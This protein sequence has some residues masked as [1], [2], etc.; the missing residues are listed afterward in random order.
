MKKINAIINEKVY[1]V[2]I[3]HEEDDMQE[4]LQHVKELPEDE[5]ML[6]IFA[7]DE[8]AI[9]WMKDTEIPLKMLFIDKDW[10]VLRVVEAEPMNEDLIRQKGAR[11]V[12]E[13]NINSEVEVGDYVDLDEIEIEDALSGEDKKILMLV[14]D[15]H[16]NSQMDLEGGERIFSRPNT[17]TLIK[18]ARRAHRTKSDRDY[19]AL[20]RKIFAYLKTQDNNVQETV[21]IPE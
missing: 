9:M 18:M 12:L 20:G 11:Y 5:G 3:A 6:F 15:L 13:L 21:E 19:K 14:L 8:E 1:S 17:K 10:E 7:E 2:K 4:G 16:G